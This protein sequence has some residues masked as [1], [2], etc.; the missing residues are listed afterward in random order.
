MATSPL[1]MTGQSNAIPAPIGGLN[2]RDSV[3]LLPET[4][5]IRLENF[6][7]ARSHVQVRNGYDD[8]VTGLPSTVLLFTT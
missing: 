6:F 8:H 3:D 7:P 2:T 1:A 5:A 4:D